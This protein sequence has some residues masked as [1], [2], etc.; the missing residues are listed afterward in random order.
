M[1]YRVSRVRCPSWNQ[2]PFCPC[3]PIFRGKMAS[4]FKGTICFINK[5]VITLQT[6]CFVVREIPQTYHRFVLFH[7]MYLKVTTSDKGHISN[8]VFHAKWVPHSDN[9]KW[10]TRLVSKHGVQGHLL[11]PSKQN[12]ESK[13]RKIQSYQYAFTILYHDT[14][15]IPLCFEWDEQT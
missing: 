5:E 11:W 15:S 14:V 1:K 7:S 10:P 2:Q 4:S 6:Q 9:G 13:I 3:H 8:L 12:R